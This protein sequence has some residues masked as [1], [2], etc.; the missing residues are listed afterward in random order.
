MEGEEKKHNKHQNDLDTNWIEN[1]P[2]TA[3]TTT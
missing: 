1:R 3:T 2:T